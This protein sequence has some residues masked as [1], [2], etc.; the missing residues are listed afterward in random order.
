M[1]CQMSVCWAGSENAGLRGIFGRRTTPTQSC[2]GMPK[3][4][5]AVTPLKTLPSNERLAMEVWTGP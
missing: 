2:I 5:P 3:G 4:I 1:E